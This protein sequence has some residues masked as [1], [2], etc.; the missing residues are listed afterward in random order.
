[1]REDP[2]IVIDG[3]G[4]HGVLSCPGELTAMMG[5]LL[6]QGSR[7]LQLYHCQLSHDPVGTFT[8]MLMC[9]ALLKSSES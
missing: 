9:A 7:C 6:G 3:V 4:G 1:M 8:S 5:W 2:T